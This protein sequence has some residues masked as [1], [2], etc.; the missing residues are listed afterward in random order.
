[1]ND[2]NFK[3]A[4]FKRYS[5]VIKSILDRVVGAIALIFVAPLLL[6]VAIA[7][8]LRMGSPVVFIQPR[9]GKN[10]RIFNFY[11]FR[12]M[13]NECDAQGNLL[14]DEK[15]LTALGKF[16]RQTS[17]DE[18]PQL[19]NVL[20]GDMSFVGP[21]PLLVKYLDLYTPQ[22]ARRHEVKPGITGWAQVNGRRT[23]DRFWDKKFELDVW[24]IDRWSLWLDLKILL[25]TVWQVIQRKS[26]SQEGHVTSEEFTGQLKEQ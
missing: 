14:A 4:K 23:L 13:T 26:I 20:K 10:A 1:M 2:R 19:W 24:Y 22:Q 3:D 9:P 15:R 6:G 7:I 17:L 5:R 8:Y 18:L 21:R 25:M 11:K 12:T 16:L